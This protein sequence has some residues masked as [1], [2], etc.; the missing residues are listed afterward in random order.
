MIAPLQPL[1]TDYEMIAFQN[2]FSV[3]LG[4]LVIPTL[5]N[6]VVYL[7]G[8]RKRE[9]EGSLGRILGRSAAVVGGLITLF[10]VA[11]PLGSVDSANPVLADMYLG[12]IRTGVW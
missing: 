8:L 1:F 6:L 7:L 2:S 4:F 11:L 9:P 12:L 3:F 5:A 10:G